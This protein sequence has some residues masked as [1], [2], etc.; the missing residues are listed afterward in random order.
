MKKVL[1][2]FLATT[3]IL[4]IGSCTKQAPNGDGQSPF[5]VPDP[6]SGTT[7]PEPTTVL[8]VGDVPTSF[9]KKIIIEKMTGE[10]CGGCPS[11]GVTIDGIVSANPDKV[12]AASWQM[13]NGDPFEIPEAQA[14]RTH[15]SAGAGLTGYSFPSASINRATSITA[16]YAN[17]ALDLNE[18]SSANWAAQT[19]TELAKPANCGI[20]L[21]T[22]EKNDKVNVDVYIGYNSP[23]TTTKTHLTVYLIEDEVP[24]SSAGAQVSGGGSYLHPH[25]IRDVLTAELGDEVNLSGSNYL[26]FEIKDFNIAGKYTNKNKLKILAFVNVKG[27][28][29]DQLSILNAQEVHLGDIKQFD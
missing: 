26:K 3:M 27:S 7:E 9:T 19:A 28:T 2:I 25:M 16:Q 17:A 10:W 20:G 24:E 15:I 5:Y 12:F 11:G 21:V 23:I 4:A 18:G 14:W 22:S 6:G 29:A 8:P 13:S 1:A